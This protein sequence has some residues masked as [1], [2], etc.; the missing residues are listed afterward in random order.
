MGKIDF[1]NEM[2]QTLEGRPRMSNRLQPSEKDLLGF[3]G[4]LRGERSSRILGTYQNYVSSFMIHILDTSLYAREERLDVGY[5]GGTCDRWSHITS[6]PL[7]RN[8]NRFII[9]CEGFAF[10]ARH[11]LPAAG[12]KFNGY[13]LLFRTTRGLH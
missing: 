4:K 5:P 10:I 11:L 12:W 2:T 13:R 9:D 6:R 3:F 7:D 8:G 1:I